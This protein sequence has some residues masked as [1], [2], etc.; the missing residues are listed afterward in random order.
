M[1]EERR[2][3]VLKRNYDAPRVTVPWTLLEPYRRQ[4]EANHYQTLERLNERGGLS[5]SEM[6]A[7]VT[8][9]RWDDVPKVERDNAEAIIRSIADVRP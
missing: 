7:V 5:W 1:S 8:N 9:R 2:F 3:R 4:A 6:L